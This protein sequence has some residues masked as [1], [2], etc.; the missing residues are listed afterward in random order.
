MHVHRLTFNARV[1]FDPTR[2]TG[3]RNRF[4]AD[5]TRRWTQ[6]QRDIFETIVTNDAFNIAADV[7][8]AE[9]LRAAV[10]A[11]PGAF[12]FPR[13]DQ[14]VQAFMQWLEA[15]QA[16]GILEVTF[17]PGIV[18]GAEG[19]WSDVYI[20]TTYQKG[21]KQARAKLR[22]AGIP[23]PQLTGFNAPM[24]ADRVGLAFSRTFS[25]LKS[26][27]QF[28]NQAIRRELAEGLTTG[29]AQ[30]IADGK[31]VGQITRELSKDV[32][33]HIDK[34]GKVRTRLIARTEVAR[35]H[36]MA[37]SAEFAQAEVEIGRPLWYEWILNGNPCQ[38]CVDLEA[39]NPYR[40]ENIAGQIP[41][42][43]QCFCDFHPV[44]L[45]AD[46]RRFDREARVAQ[47]FGIGV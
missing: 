42:H 25:E 1:P 22:R 43:P 3:I 12:D 47:E 5:G 19:A 11:P 44:T 36:H 31:S 39:G 10:A 41:V 46:E 13:T 40:L 6:H 24:H 26:V 7:E 28:T 2:T 45:P 27:T 35:A 21:F 4:A 32:N 17:R 33:N 9:R 20:Q 34:L 15:Q 14:K 8:Q 38:Q 29:L 16:N 23:V 18:A 30:G 37:L